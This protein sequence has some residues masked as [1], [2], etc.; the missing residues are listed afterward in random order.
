[1]STLWS[2]SHKKIIS[3]GKKNHGEKTGQKKKKKKKKKTK[4]RQLFL[5]LIRGSSSAHLSVHHHFLTF[6]PIM[7]EL[8]TLPKDPLLSQGQKDVLSGTIG[9]IA[10]VMVGQPLDILKV[11]LQTSPP[12]TYTGM[13]DCATRIVRNEGPLAFY[14]GTLTPLLGVGACVSIQFG[15]VEALKRRFTATNLSAGSKADLSYGQFYLAGG[16]A[17]LANS[18]VAGPIEHVRIR[19]QT[20]PSP[21]LY[22]G[23]I[24]CIRQMVSQSGLLHGVYRGQLPTFAREFHGMGMYFLTYEALV[25]YKL[26]TSN[27]ERSQLPSTYA[28]FAGAM[29]GYAL[30]LTAY[31]ADIVKS[32]LQTD[33]LNKTDRR[34]KG[35]IDC[36]QQTLRQDGIKGFFRGLLPTLVRS[37]FANAA[38]FVAFEWAA[39]NLRE[40]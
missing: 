12:G 15:V 10:Q 33:A 40:L 20:Q 16:L 31:P 34:Y 1:M 21:P 6:G 29:A 27:L 9:G 14:K 25:Q 2:R 23:P 19:L 7:A 13:V 22:R 39:R 37:P 30:W 28:M 8:N 5:V 4:R 38:T 36:I 17:G 24:D 11:R 32:K 18:F 3:S 26:S 35:A